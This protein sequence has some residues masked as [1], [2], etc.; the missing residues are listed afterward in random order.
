MLEFEYSLLLHE[1]V[2]ELEDSTA[3]LLRILIYCL[4]QLL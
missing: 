4:K 3:V 2:L 1:L